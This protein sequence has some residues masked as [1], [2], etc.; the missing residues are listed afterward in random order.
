MCDLQQLVSGTD[1]APP[2]CDNATSAPPGWCY[3]EGAAN[4]GGCAQAIRFSPQASQTLS[5]TSLLLACPVT[6]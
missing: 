6:P 2:S 4:A 3:V 1:Y 5:G